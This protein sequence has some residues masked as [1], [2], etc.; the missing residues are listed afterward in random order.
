MNKDKIIK[1]L[2]KIIGIIDSLKAKLINLYIYIKKEPKKA[3]VIVGSIFFII[4]FIFSLKLSED[5]KEEPSLIKEEVSVPIEEPIIEEPIIEEEEVIEKK[6]HKDI[7][8]VV[9]NF[10][11]I[12]SKPIL[13]DIYYTNERNVWFD[14]N[15][16]VTHQGKSGRN[17]YSIILPEDTIYRIRL[18]FGENPGKVIIRDIYL[19]GTQNFDLN[20]FSVYE[21]NQL[22]GVKYNNRGIIFTSSGNDPYM[23]YRRSLKD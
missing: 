1:N 20:D 13:F 12:T 7:D 8:K 19:S 9:L 22:E 3:I 16:Y 5:K 21:F 23:A 6:E 17:D 15:H 4:L 2:Y 18:D 10:T 14:G 11:A